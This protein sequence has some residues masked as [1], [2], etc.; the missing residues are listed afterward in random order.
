MT[1]FKE[2]CEINSC[3]L[4]HV[5]QHCY[6]C[7]SGIEPVLSVESKGEGMKRAETGRYVKVVVVLVYMNITGNPLLPF[8]SLL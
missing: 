1:D 2:K 3:N 8:Y 4:A 7:G 5:H 6:L